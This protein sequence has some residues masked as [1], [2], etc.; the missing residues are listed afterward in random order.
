[1][2]RFSV[3]IRRKSVLFLPPE[4]G[5]V[6]LLVE[7]LPKVKGRRRRKDLSFNAEKI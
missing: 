5:A 4:L 2:A 6:K 7:F 3:L 1:M